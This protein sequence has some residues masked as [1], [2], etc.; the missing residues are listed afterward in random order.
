MPAIVLW[1][2]PTLDQRE[3]LMPTTQ[4]T[5][6]HQTGVTLLDTIVA[7]LLLASCT[8][9]IAAIYAERQNI[10]RG[11]RLHEQAVK[12]AQQMA[13]TIR[14][15]SDG[16]TSFE[17]ALGATCDAKSNQT[18]KS[19]SK[20]SKPNANAVA[21]WQDNVEQDLT[22][23]TATISLDRSSVPAQYVI[24]VSWSEPRSGTASYVMRVTP[25]SAKAA[26]VEPNP[27]GATRAAG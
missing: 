23:G 10:A 18:S 17:T 8:I 15:N 1:T 19:S 7:L 6:K 25:G 13:T 14:E 4:H 24:I 21:C 27:D 26:S 3:Y 20:K 9:G 5:G 11:G 12:L 2:V 22:N 16:S